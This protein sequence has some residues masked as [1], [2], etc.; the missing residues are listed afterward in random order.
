MGSGGKDGFL[1]NEKILQ[2]AKKHKKS[3]AQVALRW[4]IQRGVIVI[5][6]SVHKERIQEN[7]QVFDFELDNEDMD[8]INALQDVKK[9]RFVKECV[10]LI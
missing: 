10:F 6:K 7:I 3:A 5:P 2:I 8:Q 4:N 9:K 1:T